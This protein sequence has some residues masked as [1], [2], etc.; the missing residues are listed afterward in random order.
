MLIYRTS[1]WKGEGKHN[2]YCEEFRLEDDC[3]VRYLC[4]RKK[5]LVGK[6]KMWDY[7]KEFVEKWSKTDENMPFWLNI[8]I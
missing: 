5:V 7:T 1:E 8:Y 2:Y 3:V 4:N 6:E